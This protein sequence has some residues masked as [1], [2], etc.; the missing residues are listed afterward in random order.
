M[1]IQSGQSRSGQAGSE[2][3]I[4]PGDWPGRSVDSK[5]AGREDSAPKSFEVARPRLSIQPKAANWMADRARP[6]GSPESPARGTFSEGF[7][8]NLGY[9]FVSTE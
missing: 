9:L 3:C 5:E 6:S 8:R 7:P 4:W 2:S 1:K